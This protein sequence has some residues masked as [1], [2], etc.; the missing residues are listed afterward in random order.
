MHVFVKGGGLPAC[1][2]PGKDTLN[3]AEDH[4][5]VENIIHIIKGIVIR[6]IIRGRSRRILLVLLIK[7]EA[8]VKA[9]AHHLY[10]RVIGQ[11]PSHSLVHLLIIS[12]RI[13]YLDG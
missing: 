4:F 11:G 13:W 2:C 10:L 8:P 6:Q 9:P 7:Q 1:L 12:S 3:S 5:L